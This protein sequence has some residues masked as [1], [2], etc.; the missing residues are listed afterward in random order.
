MPTRN[1]LGKIRDRTLKQ[2]FNRARGFCTSRQLRASMYYRSGEDKIDRA[3]GYVAVPQYWAIYKHSGRGPLLA[4]QRNASVYVWFR[5]PRNDPRLRNGIS[6][7]TRDEITHL[8][9][10]QYKHWLGENRKARAAGKLSPMIVRKAVGPMA[11][12]KKN[13]FFS[14]KSNGGL[15]GIEVYLESFAKQE[16]HAHVES[17]LRETGLKK[18]TIRVSV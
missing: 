3:S 10:K 8:T 14:D 12:H 1:L 13:P 16:A 7:T 17:W 9:A 11:K 6:P 18:K 15:F 2:A 4:G 5:N